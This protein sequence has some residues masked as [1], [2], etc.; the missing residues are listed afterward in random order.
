M[1]LKLKGVQETLLIPLWSKAM[2]VEQ[3]NPIVTDHKAV[4]IVKNLD[5]NFPNLDKEW[6]TQLSVVIRTELL[7]KAVEKF[8]AEHKNGAV[9]NL[10]CG[11]DTRYSRLDNKNYSWFDLD[12]PSTIELRRN[13]FDE[14]NSYH[15]I[16][17]SVFDYGW[18][19]QIPGD[20]PLLIIAEGLLMYFSEEEVSEL[21]KALAEKFSGAEMLIE[22]IPYSLVKQSQNS[23]LIEKQ[24]NIKANFSWGIN[25]GNEVEKLN[26][27]IKYIED[28]HY[29]DYH[30]DRWK[31]IRWLSLI[32]YFKNRFGNRIVH[33]KFSMGTA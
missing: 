33:F 14:T 20:V 30:R 3:P 18:F 15:M 5:Y 21:F 7:D 9:I 22:T 29:F 11:L 26:P 23:N 19:N 31:I 12:L 2:E 1:K 4:E 10:G 8:M 25:N 6:A 13:F 17:K 16:D 27:N 32:P 28:W 24:Y